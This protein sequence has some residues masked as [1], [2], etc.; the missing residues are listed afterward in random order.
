[1]I[2]GNDPGRSPGQV[3][4]KSG[5]DWMW[6]LVALVVAA[7]VGGFQH[8]DR[9]VAAVQDQLPVA[10]VAVPKSSTEPLLSAQ[11]KPSFVLDLETGNTAVSNGADLWW[12]FAT[13]QERALET[14]NGA[15][16]TRIEGR[17]FAAIDAA[18]LA[19]LKYALVRLPASGDASEVKAGSMIAVRTAEGNLAKLQVRSAEPGLSALNVEWVLY[20]VAPAPGT[21]A[22]APAPAATPVAP[23]APAPAVS[24][25]ANTTSQKP[26]EAKAAVVAPGDPNQWQAKLQQGLDAYRDKRST[27]ALALYAEALEAAKTFGANSPQVAFVVYRTGTLYWSMQRMNEAERTWIEALRVAL[28]L[29]EADILSQLG[30]DRAYLVADIYRGLAQTYVHQGRR[31]EALRAFGKVTTALE[32]STAAVRPE[33]RAFVLAGSYLDLGGAQCAMQQWD[34]AKAS[35]EKGRDIALKHP[36]GVAQATRIEAH[37][38]FLEKRIPC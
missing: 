16:M 19:R 32:A 36:G 21:V 34:L 12:H 4:P 27:D 1:M 28:K 3:D 17:Q 35:L 22:V 24:A 10:T 33:L 38:Q 23:A 15:L 6:V 25:D 2:P 26:A 9:L 20:R 13:R 7:G 5:S 8:K 30:L 14:R 37:L 29:R 31:D 18:F 11:V